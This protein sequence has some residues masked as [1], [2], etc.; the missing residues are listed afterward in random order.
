MTIG[1]QYFIIVNGFI[2]HKEKSLAQL[3]ND[4]NAGKDTDSQLNYQTVYHAI[5]K[6]QVYFQIIKNG[7]FLQT[8]VIQKLS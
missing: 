1:K 7:E 5:E 6:A 4:Y 3:L 8:L 2:I